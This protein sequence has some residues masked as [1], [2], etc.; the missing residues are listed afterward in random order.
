MLKLKNKGMALGVVV[1]FG[2]L[3]GLLAMLGYRFIFSHVRMAS[4][5]T[6]R[7]EALY[8]SRAGMEY[9]LFRLRNSDS[10]SFLT[11]FNSGVYAGKYY[12]EIDIDDPFG[13]SGFLSKKRRLAKILIEP[14]S[15]DALNPTSITTKDGIRNRY[16]VTST[17][18]LK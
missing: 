5:I 1:F 18:V 14:Y 8:T 6:N 9:A 15:A 10:L 3:I 7:T 17:V 2:T 11:D 13:A 4:H 16:K 12:K